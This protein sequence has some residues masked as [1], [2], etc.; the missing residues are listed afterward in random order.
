M[1]ANGMG[2]ETTY[3]VQEAAERTGL[4]VHT[5]RY[6]ERAGLL[7]PPA[8]D[9]SSGHRRYCD[10]DLRRVAFLKRLRTTGLSIREMQSFVAL[11][12]GGDS[13]VERRIGL[14]E[15]RRCHVLARIA[16]LQECLTVIEGKIDAYR[17]PVAENLLEETGVIEP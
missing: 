14:L 11:Y 16:E 3:T 6:Y 1:Y 17:R 9:G 10:A 2:Y 7:E 13:T 8:R 5:L 15:E 12:I 4:T